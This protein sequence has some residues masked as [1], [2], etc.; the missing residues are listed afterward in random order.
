MK[1]GHFIGEQWIRGVLS[2]RAKELGL[3]DDSVDYILQ[4]LRTRDETV[5]DVMVNAMFFNAIVE[6]A[7]A[8]NINI[9]ET[10]RSELTEEFIAG[11]CFVI[12]NQLQ[13]YDVKA[14][15]VIKWFEPSWEFAK[16]RMGERTRILNIIKRSMKKKQLN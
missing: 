4:D 14:E 10:D 7:N 8:S 6:R 9:E 2:K 13:S 5:T 15:E 3:D 16:A 12:Y 11:C 1:K